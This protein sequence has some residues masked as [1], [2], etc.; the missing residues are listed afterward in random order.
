MEKNLVIKNNSLKTFSVRG[1]VK[2]IRYAIEGLWAF[3]NEQH[4]AIIHLLLTTAAIIAAVVWK[5]GKTEMIAMVIVTGFVWSAEL[6]NT[7]IEKLS[8]RITGEFDPKIKFIKDVSA[9]AVLISA[10]SAFIT[11][12]IIFLPKI[13]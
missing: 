13:F 3:F 9:A 7:A 11:G 10:I 12:M 4:N 1:R 2:S 8:D 6:F 5:V